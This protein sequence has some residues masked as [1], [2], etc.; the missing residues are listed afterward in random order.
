[1]K[2]SLG[3]ISRIIGFA[4]LA[5]VSMT[6]QAL[7]C[8]TVGSSGT[9]A[10]KMAVASNFNDAAKTLAT[11]YANSQGYKI[12]VCEDS[13]GNFMTAIGTSNTPQYAVFLSADSTRPWSLRTNPSTSAL[14][15]ADPFTYAKG[16][17]VFLL[18]PNAY[19]SASGSYPAANYLNTGISGTPPGAVAERS[20]AS[21]PAISNNVIIRRP[22]GSSSVSRLAIGNPALA[23]YGEAAVSILGK[24]YTGGWNSAWFQDVG[25]NTGTAC[26][27]LTTSPQWICGYSNINNTLQAINNDVVTAGI[28]S[29]GQVCPTFNGSTYPAGRYVLFPNDPTMQDGI[30]L[31]VTD[32]TA[33]T[34]AAAFMAS[35]NIGT[36]SWNTWLT[37]NCYKSL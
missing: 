1:M 28:V 6:T 7:T 26:S 34:R 25:T 33:E 2:H 21:L 27:S 37:D 11:S 3:N 24:M 20:D 32:P 22:P 4:A 30:L 8:A 19:S 35:L 15:I 18:S 16:I 36:P 12:E 23:P 10:F 5:S 9:V 17:P 29:Y 31:H 13:S 14:T